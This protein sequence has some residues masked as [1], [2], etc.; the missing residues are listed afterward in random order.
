MLGETQI[1]FNAYMLNVL[2]FATLLFVLVTFNCYS[3][4][5]SLEINDE[6]I[7]I[8]NSK[9]LDFKGWTNF[10]FSE[11]DCKCVYGGEFFVAIK[12]SAAPT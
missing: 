8:R 11:E 12:K 10:Y 5:T 4:T 3:Q 1:K 6:I 7:P 9:N 2:R